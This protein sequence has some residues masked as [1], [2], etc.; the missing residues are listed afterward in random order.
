MKT[1]S[2]NKQVLN[3]L[4]SGQT[5]SAAQA[6]NYFG[7]YRLSARIFDLKRQG[8]DITSTL[9]F[10]KSEHWSIYSIDKPQLKETIKSVKA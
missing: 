9:K 3:W 2:Q 5:L 6:A 8:H 7:I 4:K 1:E 10:H